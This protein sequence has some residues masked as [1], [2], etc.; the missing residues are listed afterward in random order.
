MIK[1][2]VKVFLKICWGFVILLMVVMYGVYMFLFILFEIVVSGGY[3]NWLKDE[4]DLVL[5]ILIVFVI[6]FLF[7]FMVNYWVFLSLV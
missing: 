1:R 3:D 2:E 5:W 7:F 6:V 4:F